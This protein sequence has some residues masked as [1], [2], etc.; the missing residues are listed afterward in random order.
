MKNIYRSIGLGLLFCAGAI[1]MLAQ[2]TMPCATTEFTNKLRAQNPQLQADFD[3]YN[4]ALSATNRSGERSTTVYIVPVVFHVMHVN[5][6]ENISDAQIFAQMNR[7]NLDYRKLNSDTSSIVSRFDTLA[8]DVR[9]EF[10]LAQIDPNGNCTNGIERIYTHKTF[11]ADDASKVNQWPRDKYLNIWV[12]HDIAGSTPSATILGFAHFPSDV[13][14]PLFVYDGIIAVYNTINGSSRTLTHEIGHY[15]NLQHTWGSTNDPNVA[16]GDD[17]VNDTPVT[18]GHFSTCPDIDAVC[19][20]NPFTANFK[21]DSVTTTSGTTDPTAAPSLTA[22]STTGFSAVGVSA[23]SSTNGRFEYSGW[24]L[25]A[26]DGA[27]TYAALTGAISTAKYYQVKFTPQYGYN[28]KYTQI[29]FSFSRNATGVR[30]FAIRSSRDGYAANLATASVATADAANMSIQTGNVFFLKND[31]TLTVNSGKV[32]LSG[33][34]F[35]NDTMPVTFRI[36]AWNAEDAAGTFSLDSVNIIGSSDMIENVQNYMD[37]SSCTNMFSLGQ[38]DRMRAAIESPISHR[39]NLWSPENLAATGVLVPQICKPMPDFYSNKS[40][41]C[42]GD[43][44]KFTKNVLYGTPDSVRWTFYGGSPSTSTSMAP[45]NVTYPTAGLF[46]VTLTAYNAGGTDSVTKTDYVRVDPT[47]ADIPYSGSFTEDFQN[48]SDFYWKWQVNNYD[49]NANTWFVC[50]TAG[51][52]SSKSVVMTA[53]GDYQYDVDDLVSPSYDLS[54]TSGNIMTFRCAAASHAGAG[55]DVN[56]KLR[57]YVS[58]NCG[59][60]WTLAATFSDSTLINNGY[61]SGYFTPTTASQWALRTVTIPPGFNTGNVRFKFEYTSGSES[62]NIYVDDINL[63]GVVG[64]NENADAVSTLSIYPNP[65]SQSSTIA[66]RLDKKADTKIE[67]M[68]V[69][70]KSVFVQSNSGQAEGDYSVSIS[71]QNLNLRNGIY[72]VKFTVN[73]QSTTKKLIVTQ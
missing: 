12:V 14:G 44:V 7:L 56:D 69:L 6:A 26:P 34:L 8:A 25:G 70:G 60:A 51:Y 17:L 33:A 64:I 59:Q 61:S 16:C 71:K 42:A 43:I 10:R 49:N 57:V 63:A 21:F 11:Q 29:N 35:T 27:T 47:W 31:T 22:M 39:D 4:Q 62:N 48:T 53:F 5:G 68:D 55:L 19:T 30:T 37:Y 38:A 15:L 23:N 52:M 46:K 67:V 54:F 2:S 58:G 20:L 66:Y 32:T 13:A 1:S 9:L 36:Y 72:F 73:D 40:R 3:N 24:G 65:T 18:K 50:N 45:V 41:V 28:A